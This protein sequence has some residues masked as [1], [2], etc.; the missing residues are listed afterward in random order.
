MF[1]MLFIA[2]PTRHRGDANYSVDARKGIEM[3]KKVSFLCQKIIPIG[4]SY[5]I[6]WG[7]GGGIF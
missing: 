5:W 7:G 2:P 1:S 4:A 6:L 3:Q